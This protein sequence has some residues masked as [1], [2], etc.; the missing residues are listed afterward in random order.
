MINVVVTGKGAFPMEGIPQVGTKK[1]I[2]VERFSEAWMK[3]A[4]AE[5]EKAVKAYLAEKAK[6]KPAAPVGKQADMSAV[7]SAAATAAIQEV[8]ESLLERMA[9]SSEQGAAT[10]GKQPS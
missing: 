7:A 6:A 8:M 10:N 3:P 2:P 9:A 4:D 5:S 1:S